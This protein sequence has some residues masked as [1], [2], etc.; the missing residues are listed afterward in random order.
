MLYPAA[1]QQAPHGGSQVIAAVAEE[2]GGQEGEDQQDINE[3]AR[4]G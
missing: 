1:W 4:G 2:G 3:T